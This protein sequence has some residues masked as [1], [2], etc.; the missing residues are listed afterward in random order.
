MIGFSGRRAGPELRE[1]LRETGARGVILFA[2]NLR[3]A[4]HTHE[5]VAAVRRLVPWPLVVAL[6][7]EGGAV[8]RLT[9]G[10]TVFPGNM[11]L[12]AARDP[13]LALRQGRESGRQLGA[14]GI[15]WNLAP[16]VDLQ[17][18]PRNPGIGVRSFG[19][20]RV[21]AAD[22]AAALVRGHA[23]HGVG[24]CLK[25]F[26]G[27]GAAAVDAHHELPV[28]ETSLEEF[29]D[30]HVAV[31][32]DVLERTREQAPCVMTT[33]LVV[34]ALDPET[35]ATFSDPIVRGLLRGR[36][37]HTGPVLADDLEMGAV[38]RH[39]RVERA[40]VAAA[41]AGHDVLPIGHDPERQRAAARALEAA[42][43][44]GELDVAEHEAAVARMEAMAARS[45][46][47][48]PVDPAPGDAV[49]AEIAERAVCLLGDARGLLPLPAGAAVGLAVA[50]PHS[51]TLVEEIT[52]ADPARFWEEELARRG[53]ANVRARSFDADLD[54][55]TAADVVGWLAGHDVAVLASWNAMTL[56][57]SRALLTLVA[58]RLADRAVV[59]HLRNP[60]DQ[61]LLPAEV[62]AL[63]AFG[64]RAV[65]VRALCAVLA[66]AAEAV[67]TPPV[68]LD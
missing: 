57:G 67:A 65:H 15:D 23:E 31:F 3:D 39:Q 5:L 2:R 44:A 24:S 51:V 43:A 1:L 50:R 28:I 10:V 37:G 20:D 9:S 34:Q 33:H 7:Q 46:A 25:H 66:G 4:R 18:N 56:P 45:E 30:P 16:V 36:L 26:P 49:A 48:G 21:L 12:G 63:T 41:A 61:A 38:V 60:F 22:L 29:S 55:G 52:R 59:V 19:D 58:E 47:S 68:R 13:D 40:A 6:D 54:P 14:L 62:T 42:L 35:P 27:K 53:L 8:V 64:Y 32:Q 11:A 17:T